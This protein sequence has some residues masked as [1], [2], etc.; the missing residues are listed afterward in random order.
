MCI[1]FAGSSAYATQQRCD[2]NNNKVLWTVKE[3]KSGSFHELRLKAT[4]KCLDV[5]KAS[6]QDE[7]KLMQFRCHGGSNQLWDLS[8]A[9]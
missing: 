4:N 5:E 8:D 1:G 9:L 6:T 3:A 7:A 2:P